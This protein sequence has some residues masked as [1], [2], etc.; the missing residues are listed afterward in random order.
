MSS[1]GPVATSRPDAA[2]ND[3]AHAE[4]RDHGVGWWTLSIAVALALGALLGFVTQR[5]TG[6]G[7]A[8]NEAFAR[9]T[10]PWAIA[11]A[12]IGRCVPDVRTA[13]VTSTVCL[14]SA[15]IVFYA[16][17]GPPGDGGTP[18]LWLAAIIL[19]GPMLGWLGRV[20]G[21]N[22]TAAAL[23]TGVIGGW[24][25]GEALHIALAPGGGHWYG[26]GGFTTGAFRGFPRFAHGGSSRWLS[27]A[28]DG[29]AAACWVAASRGPRR[30]LAVTLLPM[31]IVAA[32][33]LS[34]AGTL[35]G[36]TIR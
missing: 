25:L 11:A 9:S 3:A 18:G 27:V 26:P 32:V 28:I 20:S 10:G 29:I 24:L 16:A 7:V 23:A 1:A 4:R 21:T 14:W 31:A 6:L 17:G 33:C 13:V 22:G 35:V 19:I 2:R 8:A 12:L 36:T 34:V 5:S 15:T 30:V